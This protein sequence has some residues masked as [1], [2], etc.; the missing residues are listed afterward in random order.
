M[1]SSKALNPAN[2]VPRSK[3]KLRR[4]KAFVHGSGVERLLI[5][6][7]I[8]TLRLLGAGPLLPNSDHARDLETMWREAH[9]L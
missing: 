6:E 9:N 5:F 1:P 8:L 7:G 2:T 4:A 3:V